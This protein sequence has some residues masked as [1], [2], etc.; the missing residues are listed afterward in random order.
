[1]IV[2][3]ESKEEGRKTRG[4]TWKRDMTI[5]CYSM[6]HYDRAGRQRRRRRRRR[7]C[8]LL[9][10]EETYAYSLPDSALLLFNEE[11]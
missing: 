4:G 6:P 11:G 8:L 3:K 2:G 10:R 5:Q 9:V 1:M 7:R